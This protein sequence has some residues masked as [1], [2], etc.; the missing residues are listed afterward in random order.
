MRCRLAERSRTGL[1]NNKLPKEIPSLVN[2][3]ASAEEVTSAPDTERAFWTFFKL[4]DLSKYFRA[5]CY[6]PVVDLGFSLNEIDVMLSLTKHP[7]RNTVKGIS[8]TVHLSRGMISQAVESLRKKKLVT[9][10]H[11]K[12]DRRS[13]LITLSELAT[14]ILDTI[15]DASTSFVQSIING[16]PQDQLQEVYRVVTQV[17]TNKEKMKALPATGEGNI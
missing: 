4:M 2:D 9:V 15:K 13:V 7:D 14:P 11:D 5:Y 1:Q 6:K 16:V 12:K 10:D 8:E 17:Y 3:T